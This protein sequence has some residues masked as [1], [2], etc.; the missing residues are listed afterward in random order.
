MVRV[1]GE[2][3]PSRVGPAVMFALNSVFH[4]PAFGLLGWFC[5]DLLPGRPGG[6]RR[7]PRIPMWKIAQSGVVG[8]L[9]E[10][11][12]LVALVHVSPAWRRKFSPSRRLTAVARES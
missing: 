6:R 10:V 9:I 2:L 5:P 7:A 12:V 8:T 4:V 11:P 1:K 3:W